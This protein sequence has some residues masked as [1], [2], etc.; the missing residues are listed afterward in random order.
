MIHDYE[1]K[2][3]TENPT[4]YNIHFQELAFESKD[5]SLI[6]LQHY[7]LIEVVARAHTPSMWISNSCCGDKENEM[8]HLWKYRWRLYTSR[9]LSG[10]ATG[11][12]RLN[13]NEEV[14]YKSD[15]K[16]IIEVHAYIC[17][18]INVGV[19]SH[20]NRMVDSLPRIT[21]RFICSYL[22]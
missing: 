9:A 22:A 3:S 13:C 17:H 7:W 21:H 2:N 18:I 6:W 14:D 1:K 8:R 20:V 16:Q 10:S 11:Q 4:W 19:Q 15:D 12:Q 5:S